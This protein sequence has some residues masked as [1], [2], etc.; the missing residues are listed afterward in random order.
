M[1]E[2]GMTSPSQ[3][4]ANTKGTVLRAYNSITGYLK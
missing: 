3:Q 1:H 4:I 2:Y